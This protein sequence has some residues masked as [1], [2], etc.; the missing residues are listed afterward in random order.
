MEKIL[1]LIP[2]L[3]KSSPVTQ[4]YGMINY[5]DPTKYRAVV[6]SVFKERNN[7]AQQMFEERGVKVINGNLDRWQLHSQKR[8]LKA[9]IKNENPDIIHSCSVLTDGICSDIKTV[10][11]IILTLHC[12][13]YEDVITRYGKLLGKFMCKREEKAIRQAAAAVTVSQTLA[14]K[15]KRIIDRHFIPIQ[16]GI[17]I[18]LWKIDEGV[19]KKTLREKL[20]LPMS[21][22]VILSTNLLDSIK[23]PLLLIQAFKEAKIPNSMLIMLGDGNSEAEC[24]RYEAENIVFTG[25]VNNVKDYLYA[26]DVLVSASKSEGMPYAIL[27]AKCTGIRMILSDIPQHR[28]VAGDNGDVTFFQVVNKDA[29]I[30]ALKYQRSTRLKYDMDRFTASFMSGEYQRIYSSITNNLNTR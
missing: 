14:E 13:I 8:M 3:E 4:L 17:E 27:E 28:E 25:R 20:N 18:S 21:T 30:K 10:K 2:H 11:P 1:Y 16:N 9:I 12:F 5:L 22:Y 29:L 24:K 23:D 6:L 26:S 19:T 7:S 15:Y